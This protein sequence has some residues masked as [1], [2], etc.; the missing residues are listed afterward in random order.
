MERR[1]NT[2]QRVGRPREFILEAAT[3]LFSEKGYAGTTMRD[4]ARAVGVLPGSLYAHIDSKETLLLEIVE[5]GIDRF[6]TIAEGL[7]PAHRSVERLRSA[8]R[9]HLAVVAENPQRTLVV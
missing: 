7:D 3:Q 8:V 2:R 5:S 9:M 4:I 1:T 6:L